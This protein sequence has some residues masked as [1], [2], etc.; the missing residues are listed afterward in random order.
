MPTEAEIKAAEE[1]ATKAD[2]DAKTA[3]AEEARLAG[4]TTDAGKEALR[5]EREAKRIAEKAAKTAT[6]ELAAL[7]AEK[8][9]ADAAKAKADEFEALKRGEHEQVIAAKTTEAEALKAR[10]DAAEKRLAAIDEQSMKRIE[11]GL[12]AIPDDL[13]EFDPGKDAP[14]D[15]RLA[16]FEKASEIANTRKPGLNP[17]IADD[18]QPGPDH[19][20]QGPRRRKRPIAPTSRRTT[21]SIRSQ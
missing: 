3:E 4:I 19:Q 6:E 11:A 2:A 5:K 21:Y 9:T 8:A 7:K 16:W 13:K 1:A 10:V 14:L 12:A 20:S 15:T 17:A 18:A